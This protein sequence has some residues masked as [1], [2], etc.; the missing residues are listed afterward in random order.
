MAVDV[1]VYPGRVK[2]EE[3]SPH[4]HRELLLVADPHDRTGARLADQVADLVN[5]ADYVYLNRV[6]DSADLHRTIEA[7]L[8]DVEGTEVR[9]E[10]RAADHVVGDVPIRGAKVV[11]PADEAAVVM[12]EPPEGFGSPGEPEAARPLEPKP[13]PSLEDSAGTTHAHHVGGKRLRTGEEETAEPRTTD[14]EP[15]SVELAPATTDVTEEEAAADPRTKDDLRGE[16]E[17]AGLPVSGSKRD[18]LQRLR[19]AGR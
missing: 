15:S 4:A 16:L 8:Q 5:G 10:G 2:F 19:D 6:G 17:A 13:L 1:T 9:T 12:G 3:Q 7:R 14:A 11:R 18:Q